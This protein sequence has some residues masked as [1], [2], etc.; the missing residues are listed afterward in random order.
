MCNVNELAKTYFPPNVYIT[1]I[2]TIPTFLIFERSVHDGLQCFMLK[3]WD[4]IQ[5]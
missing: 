5:V 1:N 2:T 4:I 3:T